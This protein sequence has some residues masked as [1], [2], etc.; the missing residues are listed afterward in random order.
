MMT[1]GGMQINYVDDIFPVKA[2]IPVFHLHP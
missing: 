1:S 2:V